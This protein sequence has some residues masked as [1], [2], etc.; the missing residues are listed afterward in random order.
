MPLKAYVSNT[1]SIGMISLK[2]LRLTMALNLQNYLSW[3]IFPKP[4]FI[5]LILILLVTKE[6]LKD[7]MILFAVSFL[8]A[9][10]S[11]T[12]LS[13]KS[14]ILKLGAI[15]CQ[16]RYWLIIHQMKS[17]KENWIKSIKQLNQKCSIYYC[18]LQKFYL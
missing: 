1:V 11:I 5:M 13:N 6:L 18:N 3:K 14:L 9:T 2:L 16:E 7:I 10:I 17:L 8:K 12:I 4:W 15:H